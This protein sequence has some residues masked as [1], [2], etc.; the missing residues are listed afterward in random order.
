MRRIQNNR[1]FTLVEMLI[2]AAILGLVMVAVY[3]LYI[4]TQRT[5]YTSEEVVD[6]Q[7]NLRI[8][9]DTM[10]ADIRMAGFLTSTSF[11]PVSNGPDELSDT[12]KLILQAPVSSGVYARAVDSLDIANNGS[13][14]IEVDT[15]MGAG[16]REPADVKVLVMNPV[17]LDVRGILTLPQDGGVSGDDDEDLLLNNTYGDGVSITERDILLK[18]AA[19]DDIKDDGSPVTISYY[20][21]VDPDSTDA[22]LMLLKRSILGS[23]AGATEVIE[24]V[25][26]GIV[27]VELMYLDDNGENTAADIDKTS[28]VSILITSGTEDNE[29]GR[30]KSR[31][32]QTVVMIRNVTGV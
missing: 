8:A 27:S 14:T 11:D 17:N 10:V 9:M 29:V 25:A 28:A 26:A 16:F 4:N 23:K 13:A 2:V 24:T 6:A 31:Q 7:Q 19:A 22:S 3:S 15:L 20:L 12:N 5:A 32:L 30:D 1:G 18:C 21:D